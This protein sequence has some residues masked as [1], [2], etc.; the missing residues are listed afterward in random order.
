[1]I[2]LW[3]RGIVV[4]TNA[5]LHSTKPQLRF[6]PCSERVGDLQ[7]CRSLIMVPTGNKAKR[8][9]SANHT[10]ITTHHFHH[11]HVIDFSNLHLIDFEAYCCYKCKKKTVSAIFLIFV[12]LK[13]RSPTGRTPR[14]Q[15]FV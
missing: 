8:F 7:W 6:K 3:R 11:Y 12:F 4:I 1:M 5:Q 14:L 15:I 10:T 13:S 2:V 9:S